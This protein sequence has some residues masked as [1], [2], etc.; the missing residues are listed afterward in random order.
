MLGIVWTIHSGVER[1]F[2]ERSEGVL[3]ARD[4]KIATNDPFAGG[5]RGVFEWSG[6]WQCSV[7]KI[8]VA[9]SATKCWSAVGRACSQPYRSIFCYPLAHQ[10]SGWEARLEKRLS[11][12]S[13]DCPDCRISDSQL[14][15]VPKVHAQIHFLLPIAEVTINKFLIISDSNWGIRKNLEK[16][17]RKLSTTKLNEL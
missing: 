12:R 11:F 17:R 4:L 2:V 16:F 7:N 5:A 13:R 14:R 6:F 15:S 10:L 1:A 8:S 9:C 3:N